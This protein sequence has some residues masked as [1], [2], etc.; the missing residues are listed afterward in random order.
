M[1]WYFRT[2]FWREFQRVVA[3]D[4]RSTEVLHREAL[5][6]KGVA[7]SGTSTGIK[8]GRGGPT[9][10][11]R[12]TTRT[13]ETIE[14]SGLGSPNPMDVYAVGDEVPLFYNPDNPSEVRMGQRANMLDPSSL[15]LAMG[16]FF[17]LGTFFMVWS[18]ACR[19]KELRLRS[20]APFQ[21]Q[22]LATPCATQV[23]AKKM[24]SSLPRLR[25]ELSIDTF[26]LALQQP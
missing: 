6:S 21:V 13:G 22:A 1:F 17:L 18:L 2:A 12:F 24:R 19:L 11:V 4:L 7:V 25:V 5:Q 10:D 14:A 9:F 26:L 8:G 3:G 15:G 16:L 23:S 20:Q